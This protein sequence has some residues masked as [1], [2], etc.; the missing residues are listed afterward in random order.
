MTDL[1][2][3]TY[4]PEMGVINATEMG[5]VENFASDLWKA[6]CVINFLVTR[7]VKNKRV[8]KIRRVIINLN[9]CLS[10]IKWMDFCHFEYSR[11]CV[12]EKTTD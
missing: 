2:Y 4:M 3:G 6:V 7:R 12:F 9:A 10:C 1:G 8:C 11:L 5:V